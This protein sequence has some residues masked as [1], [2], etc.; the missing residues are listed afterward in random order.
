M[1][2]TAVTGVIWLLDKFIWRSKRVAAAQLVSSEKDKN[3]LLAEPVLVEYSISFFPVLA[4]V[5]VLR[6]FRQSRSFP[7]IHG[8]D[9]R[10]GRLYCGE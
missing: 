5:L 4:L 6:S 7:R 10:N 8:A 2:A 9:I 3:A 1:I